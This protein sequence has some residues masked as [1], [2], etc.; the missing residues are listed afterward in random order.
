MRFIETL[1]ALLGLHPQAALLPVRA[2]Q[3]P[4]QPWERRP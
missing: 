3:R 2:Q 4:R 1:L